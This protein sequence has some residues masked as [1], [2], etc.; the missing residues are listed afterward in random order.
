MYYDISDDTTTVENTDFDEDKTQ[1][2]TASEILKYFT[3]H[4]HPVS[5]PLLRRRTAWLQSLKQLIS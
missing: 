1:I 4:A 2:L 5:K 3:G